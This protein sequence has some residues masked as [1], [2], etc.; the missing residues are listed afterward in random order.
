MGKQRVFGCRFWVLVAQAAAVM[1]LG[2]PFCVQ[3]AILYRDAVL[4]TNPVIYWPLDETGGPPYPAAVDIAPLAGANNAAY[5]K[6]SDTNSVLTL[7]QAGPRPTDGF[8]YMPSDNKAPYANHPMTDQRGAGTLYDALYTTAGVPPTAY[9]VQVWFKQESLSTEYPTYI[10]GRA[11]GIAGDDSQNRDCIGIG[12]GK[13]GTTSKKIYFWDGQ[14]VLNSTSPQSVEAGKWYHLVYIRDGNSFTTYLNGKPAL[15]GTVAWRGGDGE[16]L[17]IGMR[18]DK[19][20]PFMSIRGWYDEAAV[21]NRVL[22][23]AEVRSLYLAAFPEYP[24]AILASLPYAYWRLNEVVG[25][26]LAY[27]ISGNGRDQ[28]LGDGQPPN[29]TRSGSPPDVGPRPTD[30]ARNGARLGGF[31]PTNY[32]PTIPIGKTGWTDNDYALVVHSTS[33]V[34]VPDTQYTVEAWIRPSNTTTYG[35][36]GYI[37]HRRDFDGSGRFGDALGMGGTYQAGAPAGALFYY[38][39][40]TETAIWAPN[41]TILQPNQWYHVAFVRQGDAIRVYIDGQLEFSAIYPLPSGTNFDQ[42]T[43][44]FGGRSDT[45][46]LKWPGNIDEVAIFGRALSQ[47]EIL[48][49]F[50]AALV[51]EPST[52]ILLLLSGLAMLGFRMGKR[53]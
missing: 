41:P 2:E 14:T 3:G 11:N 50:N 9:T 20:E 44:V 6:H 47:Q 19:S 13:F 30:T 25:D 26:N 40:D 36:V 23:D 35:L 15:S 8:L 33:P 27:D 39:K 24:R 32:A 31:E 51:P 4:G 1:L 7:G 43:W 53:R 46:S 17:G 52:W 18:A 38:N 22:T 21:W 34:V 28:T 10:F 5:L 37:F 48:A 16:R 42:G 45:N 49:H 12:S 29:V